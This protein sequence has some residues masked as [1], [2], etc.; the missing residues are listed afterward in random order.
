MSTHGII[1]ALAALAIASSP[2]DAVGQTAR[3]SHIATIEDLLSLRD[4]GGVLRENV[5]PSPDGDHI[6]FFERAM[7]LE[8]NRYV[9]RLIIV[10]SRTGRS[11][12]I[13]EAGNFIFHSVRGRRSGAP[14]DRAPLWSPDSSWIYYLAERDGAVEI[15][16]ARNDGSANEQV[17]AP[18]GDVRR[19]AFTPAG[20]LMLE[21][22]TPRAALAG[23]LL[24][25]QNTGFLVEDGFAPLF[26]RLPIPDE[27]GGAETSVLELD[28]GHIRIATDVERTAF[29][30]A[31]S[32][33]VIAALDPESTADTPALG[34]TYSAGDTIVRC[35]E[36]ACSGALRDAWVF[37]DSGEPLVIF[38]RL[39]G[40]A[41]IRTSLYAW[42][43][44]ENRT[45][46]IRSEVDRLS[47]CVPAAR[48]LFCL[49][50]FATQP[51]RLV[52]ID[53][54]TG[55]TAIFYDPNPQW[56]AV[57]M[58]RI[59]T[60]E[61]TDA[62]G[63]QSFAQ[64]VYPIGYRRGRL[65]PLV[66]VQYRA[67]GF[68]NAGTGSEVPIYPL[69]ARGFFVLSVERP[70]FDER[71]TRLST[72]ALIRE[73]EFDGSE[74]RIKRQAILAF[75]ETLR[76]RRMIDPARL[77]ISGMSDG[78]ETAFDMITETDLF[79]ATVVASPPNGPLS[80]SLQSRRFRSQRL[81]QFGMT[82]PWDV[83]GQNH[84]YWANNSAELRADR[85]HAALLINAPES[86]M[87]AAFGLL[88]RLE[89]TATPVETY[90]Y[91]G[92]YHLKWLPSQI[93][94]TQERTV[95]WLDF[96]LR[97]VTPRDEAQSERWRAMRD[98]QARLTASPSQAASPS[99]P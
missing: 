67:R 48:R 42:H 50:D 14:L 36:E 76:T 54:F 20:A 23:Q 97:D 69:S 8:A 82:P 45:R 11:R 92:A 19:I 71:A 53:P 68:L 60:L 43:L 31:P 58:P 79:R 37:D 1:F 65:Y 98:R 41:R 94:S 86:E 7:D 28:T 81:E 40:H 87:L 27:D 75:I 88:A 83:D 80:Y 34:L 39:E 4:I 21:T 33:A 91:P 93:R 90:I 84:A 96:W 61:H 30:P 77:G 47:G 26:S 17:L 52:S 56:S 78:A 9:H 57:R 95:A 3:R 38:R 13:A 10:E 66:V 15:W 70:E 24:Q 73:T 25:Q 62:E 89:Q 22:S 29:D 5:V 85:L 55:A 12:V 32:Q 6:A 44:G 51:R 2:G 18:A 46:L 63:N 64:L 49:Q 35:G 59:E 99:S 16:R 72:T 74:D